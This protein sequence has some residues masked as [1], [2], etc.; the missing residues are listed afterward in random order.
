[1]PSI[2]SGLIPERA[3]G[4]CVRPHPAS[5][6]NPLLPGPGCAAVVD[7]EVAGAGENRAWLQAVEAADRVAEMGGIGIADILRQMGEIDV[8]VGEMQQMPSAFPGAERTERDPGL[9]LEE[10]QEA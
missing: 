8:L 4:S 7:R 3:R 5:C 9:F 2:S 6:V 10:M 1:M